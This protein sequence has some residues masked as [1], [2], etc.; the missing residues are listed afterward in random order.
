MVFKLN[1]KKIL[2]SFLYVV[3][4]N[5]TF[6]LNSGVKMAQTPFKF[7]NVQIDKT[8]HLGIGRKIVVYKATC[9]GLACAAKMLDTR[10]VSENVHDVPSNIKTQFDI[11]SH[12]QHPNI[13]QYLGET[14]DF[15]TGQPVFLV[16][17]MDQNLTQYLGQYQG[18]LP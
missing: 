7:Q 18:P 6:R 13:I 2:P 9:D 5:G 10:D 1:C 15:E 16:E 3:F 14:T 11:L 4:N 8:N 12:C 17:L